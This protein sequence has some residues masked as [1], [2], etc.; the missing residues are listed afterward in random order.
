M[1]DKTNDKTTMG[2]KSGDCLLL[3]QKNLNRKS[4]NQLPRNIGNS[5]AV[6]KIVLTDFND[7]FEFHLSTERYIDSNAS[8]FEASKL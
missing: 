8:R 5:N 3:P 6:D 2:R 7:A 4:D 1:A